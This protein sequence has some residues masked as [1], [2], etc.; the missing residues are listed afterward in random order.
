MGYFTFNGQKK[1]CLVMLRGSKRPGWAQ[2]ERGFTE[3]PSRPGSILSS[4]KTKA[5]E[6][7]VPVLVQYE[8][9]PDLRK[10]EEELASWLITDEPK[11]LVFYDEPDRIY[12]A[13]VDGTLDIEALV[14]MGTGEITFICPDPYKYS[15]KTKTKDFTV[16]TEDQTVATVQN[17]GSVEA[18]PN[19]RFEFNEDTMVFA[20]KN[21]ESH[22]LFGQAHDEATGTIG[23][24]PLNWK[25]DC[26]SLAGWTKPSSVDSGIVSANFTTNGYSFRVPVFYTGEE[27][28][29]PTGWHGAS[30]AKNL[31][32]SI[33]DFKARLDFGFL[34]KTAAELGRVELYLLDDTGGH[35]GKISMRDTTSSGKHPRAEARA[36]NVGTG[37]NF[38]DT[39]GSY[40]G[41]WQGMKDGI[42]EIERIG[43]QWRAY[44][45]I[46][47][48]KTKKQHTKYTGRWV[49]SSKKYMKP[50]AGVQIHIGAYRTYKAIDGMYISNISVTEIRK[51]VANVTNYTFYRGDVLEINNHTGEILLNGDPHYTTLDPTSD[52]LALKPGE[53]T[54]SIAPAVVRAAEV[55]FTERWL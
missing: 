2:I 6:I 7:T 22:L 4:T 21:E 1:D 33:Q 16:L 18:F 35:I 12:Y 3:I 15:N 19:L 55:S 23:Q 44:F 13:V 30:I 39:Y 48:S 8:S 36:G 27:A 10:L 49:D 45:C 41:V 14:R 50:V 34:A 47:D 40:A 38:V 52:F 37:K 20:V 46:Y 17:S 32:Y 9:Q 26:S 28:P 11:P 53:N 29:N 25:D 42:M 51:T 5:R 31:T 24:K 54:L 43:N